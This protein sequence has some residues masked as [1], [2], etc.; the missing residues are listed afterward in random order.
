M[1]TQTPQDSVIVKKL[2]DSPGLGQYS[3]CPLIFIIIYVCLAIVSKNK[4]DV[5]QSVHEYALYIL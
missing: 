2:V 1:P 3:A 4:N 5:G